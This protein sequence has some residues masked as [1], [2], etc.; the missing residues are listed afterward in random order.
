MRRI[1]ILLASATAIAASPAVAKDDQWYAGPEIGVIWP[2]NG[3]FETA[4]KVDLPIQY[5]DG[6]DGDLLFGYDF[7]TFRLEAEAGYKSFGV[8]TLVVP[9]NAPVFGANSPVSGTFNPTSDT[10]VLSSMLNFLVDVG[11][12][13]GI[14]FSAG[15]GVGLAR[16]DT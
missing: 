13:D 8:K 7:G 10:D 2:A 6:I 11:G 1:A 5:D 9:V 4:N 14:G 16:V 3:E 15:G 12:N